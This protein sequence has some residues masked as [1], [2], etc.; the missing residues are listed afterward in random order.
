MSKETQRGEN[1]GENLASAASPGSPTSPKK[2]KGK[3]EIDSIYQS[4]SNVKA[5]GDYPPH[6]RYVLTP[7]SAEACL[8]TGVDPEDLRIRDLDSFWEPGL[9]PSIQALRH[10]AYSEM[11]FKTYEMVKKERNM[12]KNEEM[13]V[14]KSSKEKKGGARGL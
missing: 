7:R 4:V 5:Y 9:D 2:R 13:R 10:E 12:I 3:V 1:G 6:P 11:R 14:A 8:R